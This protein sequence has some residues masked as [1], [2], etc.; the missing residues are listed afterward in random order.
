M[1]VNDRVRLC[2]F[3]LL[4]VLA[5]S[6]AAQGAPLSPY[7]AFSSLSAAQLAGTQVRFTFV[8][9]SSRPFPTFAFTT[10]G[11]TLDLSVFLPYYRRN[12]SYDADGDAKADCS[13]SATQMKALIDSIGT[14]PAVTDGGVDSAECVS[15]GLFVNV[16]GQPQAFESILDIASSRDLTAKALSALASNQ[17]AVAALQ[18]YG[19]ALGLFAAGT[20]TIVDDQVHVTV[21]GF[22]RQRGTTT[23]TGRIRIT[24]TSPQTIPGP[25]AVALNPSEE[26]RIVSPTGFTCAV[27]PGGTPYIRFPST[28]GLA[29]NA[30]TEV[31]V[32]VLNPSL[33][34]VSFAHI[35]VFVDT[36]VR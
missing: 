4:I 2:G 25:L 16:T 35:R 14:L 27:Q 5:S 21:G 26:V 17:T 10:T 33:T 20:A 1:S 31:T 8:G 6:Q 12:F 23:F 28:S 34:R 7:S 19:C 3:A 29:P 22:R 32:K 18:S 15:F 36:G 30:T 9:G 24:N 13:V 11:A